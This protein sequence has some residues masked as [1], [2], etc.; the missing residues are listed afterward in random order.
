[1]DPKLLA[2]IRAGDFG[3]LQ[4][5]WEEFHIEALRYNDDDDD[6]EDEDDDEDD[7]DE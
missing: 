6:D 2:K 5:D 4:Q 7:D 1:V 3:E